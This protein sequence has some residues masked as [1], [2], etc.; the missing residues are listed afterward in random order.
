MAI[1]NDDDSGNLIP[2][3]DEADQINGNGGNDTILGDL[4]DTVAGGTGEDVLQG[5]YISGD[6]GN[7]TILADYEYTGSVNGGSGTDTLLFRSPD[8]ND[9]FNFTAEVESIEALSIQSPHDI[10]L[11]LKGDQFQNGKFS[12]S[13]LISAGASSNKIV[14]DI[15]KDGDVNLEAVSFENWDMDDSVH[16]SVL[17][18]TGTVT[19]TSQNDNFEIWLIDKVNGGGGNDSFVCTGIAAGL[20]EGGDGWDKLIVDEGDLF[21]IDLRNCEEIAFVDNNPLLIDS[22]AIKSAFAIGTRKITGAGEHQS[23]IGIRTVNDTYFDA[24]IVKAQGWGDDDVFGI[25]GLSGNEFIKG[26]VRAE[27]VETAAGSDTVQGGGGDDRI[28]GGADNDRL[29]G[30]SGNDTILGGDGIDTLIGGQGRDRLE[31]GAGADT[32]LYWSISHSSAGQSTRDHIWGFTHK[33]KIDVS[34]IDVK[35]NVE[36]DHAF[37]IDSDGSFSRGEI[38]I[39]GAGENWLIAFN[40]DADAE[41][42][43]EIVLHNSVKPW[44]SDFVL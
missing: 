39:T 4:W 25:E 29:S 32:F 16:I 35:P 21:G 11:W 26:A 10:T 6:D 19:G 9:L 38:R 31:G 28:D 33:D 22:I 43:M 37:R 7:D 3:T 23:M 2:G 13:L 30:Q 41:A 40:T 14:V 17:Q 18:T 1:I 27:I 20:V 24:S 44:A 15:D 42:D 34:F 12:P 36:G 5:T 8:R